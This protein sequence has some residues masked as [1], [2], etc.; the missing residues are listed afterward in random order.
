VD[1]PRLRV[2]ADAGAVRQASAA[3]EAPEVRL[4]GTEVSDILRC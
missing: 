4:A 1:V 3:N 2:G